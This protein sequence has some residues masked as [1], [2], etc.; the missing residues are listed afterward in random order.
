MEFF[1]RLMGEK[2]ECRL[3]SDAEEMSQ[4]RVLLLVTILVLPLVYMVVGAVI[5]SEGFDDQ[6]RAGIANLVLGAVLGGIMGT[7]FGTS[8]S[9]KQKDDTI[10]ELAGGKSS[11][12]DKGV[13]DGS[14]S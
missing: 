3:L 1:A 6:T 11:S 9:S 14:K 13:E 4:Q 2:Y 10:S 12:K 5:F 8:S 7:F